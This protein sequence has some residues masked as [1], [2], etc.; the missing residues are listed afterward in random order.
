VLASDRLE[1]LGVT[2]DFMSDLSRVFMPLRSNIGWFQSNDLR[3]EISTRVKESILLYDE[4][5]IE[6]GTF[7]VDI[8]EGSGF[9]KRYHPPG[10]IPIEQRTIEYKRDL[11]PT[12]MTL[13]IG[14]DDADAPTAIILQGNASTRFKIDYHEIFKNAELSDFDFIKFIILNEPSFPEEAKRTIKDQSQS[15]KSQF[16][17]L[18]SNKAIRNLIIDNLNHDLISSILLK[19]SAIFDSMHYDLLKRKCWQKESVFNPTQIVEST[20]IHQLLNIAVPNFSRLSIEEVVELRDEKSWSSFR[21]FIGSIAST[22]KDDP[23][24]LANSA[25]MEK[26][27]RYNC[28]EALLNALKNKSTTGPTLGV[29]LGLGLLSLIPGYGIIP[30]AVS[31]AKSIKNHLEDK[32]AWYAFIFKMR[33]G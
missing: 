7:S 3:E 25:E 20:A 6:D 23:E 14:P 4:L 27:I 10:S 33:A 32:S 30:T 26:A 13:G 31:M 17:D 2:S 12:E 1:I 9:L 29:D 11:Q 18:H 15:D 5:C 21:V 22:V 24:L 8:V 28:D 19:S 16:I